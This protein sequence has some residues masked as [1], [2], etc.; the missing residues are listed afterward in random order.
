MDG[1]RLSYCRC[2]SVMHN[3]P[4]VSGVS[5]MQ[6]RDSRRITKG[7]TRLACLYDGVWEINWYGR[8]TGFLQDGVLLVGFGLPRA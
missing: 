3:R 4:E 5:E 8:R 6:L 2:R 7:I 1:R